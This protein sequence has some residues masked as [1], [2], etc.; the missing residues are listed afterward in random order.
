MKIDRLDHF[1]LTVASIDVTCEFYRRVLGFERQSLDG[2]PI[3]L[4][5]GR[6]KINVHQADRT[7]EPKAR[8][9]T[10]GAADFCLVTLDP[11][12]AIVAHLGRCGVA[13]EKGPVERTG[14]VGPMTS[15]YFRDPDGNLIE[16]SRYQSDKS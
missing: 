2:K 5:F 6:Q 16:V 14:A 1:V 10:P 3:S 15:V 8:V 11:I 9:P 4:G 13:I 7:F 12:D